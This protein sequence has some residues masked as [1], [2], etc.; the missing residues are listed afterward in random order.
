MQ[1]TINVNGHKIILR[2]HRKHGGFIHGRAT[3]NRG[4]VLVLPSINE[5]TLEAGMDRL[6]VSFVS[7]HAES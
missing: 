1:R 5:L 7:K 6:F 4:N 2:V 3:D